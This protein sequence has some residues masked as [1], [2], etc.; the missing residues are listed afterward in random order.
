MLSSKINELVS[1]LCKKELVIKLNE[2][3]QYFA[4]KHDYDIFCEIIENYILDDYSRAT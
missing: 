1:N 4:N 3:F 2:I